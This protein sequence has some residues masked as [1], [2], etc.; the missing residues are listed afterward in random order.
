[1]R[2]QLPQIFKGSYIQELNNLSFGN[3][4]YREERIVSVVCSRF[5]PCCLLCAPERTDQVRLSVSPTINCDPARDKLKVTVNLGDLSSCLKALKLE[6]VQTVT[7]NS[8]KEGKIR[9]KISLDQVA[10][11]KLVKQLAIDKDSLTLTHELNFAE[12]FSAEKL[13]ASLKTVKISPVSAPPTW[14]PG[15]SSAGLLTDFSFSL[16]A[17]LVFSSSQ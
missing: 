7:L 6:L 17:T 2:D 9:D 8:W 13:S 3:P 16:R 1:V 15:Y 12:C 14:L 10:C 4:T 11:T 5:G